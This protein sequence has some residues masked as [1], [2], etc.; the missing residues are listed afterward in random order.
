[1]TRVKVCGITR[2]ADARLVA[3]LGAWAI[4]LI[5][6]PSSPRA[7]E[8]EHAEEIAAELRRELEVTGVFVNTPLDEVAR[9]VDRCGLTMLQF[10][11]EEGPAYCREA[12]RRTGCKV[13]KAARVKDAAAVRALEPFH[14]DYHLLDA[15]VEGQRGGTGQTFAWELARGHRGAAPLVL[16]GGLTPENVTAAITSAQPFAVDTAS[17]TETSPGRKD[18]RALKAFFRAVAGTSEAAPPPVVA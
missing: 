6:D 14:V 3:S 5:F 10:H 13:I 8:L 9:V 16:S 2:A 11:G 18:E 17:G 7:C 12:G 4:G 1:M 15:Y